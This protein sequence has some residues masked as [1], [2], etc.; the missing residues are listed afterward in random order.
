MNPTER[1]ITYAIEH[2]FKKVKLAHDAKVSTSLVTF[3]FNKQRTMS[4]EAIA[5]LCN[6][7]GL[8]IQWALTGKEPQFKEQVIVV[9]DNLVYL[10]MYKNVCLG[11]GDA[12]EPTYEEL[13]DVEPFGVPK[14][15]ITSSGANPKYCKIFKAQGDSMMPTINDGDLVV[16]DT[17]W[18]I[19]RIIDNH[20]YALWDEDYLKLKRLVKD[21]FKK[22]FHIKSDNPNYKEVVLSFDEA[23]RNKVIVLGK[24]ILKISKNL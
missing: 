23:E 1:L 6:A 7:W 18:P 19:E 14:E 13:Q 22:E 2:N 10:K 4:D 5:N 8:E 12:C 16:L 9:K 20:I 24:V 21:N 15:W 11:C 3:W 17:T